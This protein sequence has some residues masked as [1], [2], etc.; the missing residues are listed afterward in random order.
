MYSQSLAASVASSSSSAAGDH[1]STA[2]TEQSGLSLPL[3]SHLLLGGPAAA[4]A[5]VHA[6]EGEGDIGGG[7][8]SKAASPPR[9]LDEMLEV[10]GP[11]SPLHL[12]LLSLS[13]RSPLVVH[14]SSLT[15]CS[16][17]PLSIPLPT[18]SVSAQDFNL[19]TG[20]TSRPATVPRPPP[21]TAD[22]RFGTAVALPTSYP[23]VGG[24]D[25][26][27][28]HTQS[29]GCHITRLACVMCYFN[30]PS[31]CTDFLTFFC[32][33]SPSS[34]AEPTTHHES[35]RHRHLRSGPLPSFPPLCAF[36]TSCHP[37]L[38]P[39]TCVCSSLPSRHSLAPLPSFQSS[40][41]CLSIPGLAL[42]CGSS[43]RA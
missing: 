37:H 14:S 17:L 35:G 31:S 36:S 18:P 16:L 1:G 6:G 23:Q 3:L 9:S 8:Q 28:A 22:E 5:P 34:P 10:W 33:A 13:S 4:P 27:A 40:Y 7:V 25:P 15:S 12:S 43:R 30:T 2:R 11:L 19:R 41:P 42:P 24:H 32:F 29:A 38:N 21:R 39:R 26:A 20:R